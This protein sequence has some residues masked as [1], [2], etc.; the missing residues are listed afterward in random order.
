MSKRTRSS[1][2]SPTPVK[3]GLL[4]LGWKHGRA[5]V[6]SLLPVI[7]IVTITRVA[8]A[9]AYRIPSG[10]MEPTLLVGDW[11]FVNKLRFGPHIPFTHSRLPSYADPRRGDVV[12]FES[13]PQDPSIRITPDDITP[14]LVKRLVG[15]SGDTLAMRGGQLFVNGVADPTTRA[16][17][18]YTDP[19]ALQPQPIFQWQHGIE[20]A[21][22][23]F[24]AATRE[25]SLHEWGPLVIPAGM[26]F[27]M[28]DNRDNS[29]DSRFYGPVPRENVR[30][31]P[32][33]VYYSYD[34]ESGI[35]Y[36]RAVTAIRW[37]RL[38]TWIH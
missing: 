1:G 38:G 9:E 28:G 37:R 3:V 18:A 10:S 13:P 16:A 7:A 20:T 2:A 15:M 34:T 31:N 24:G 14:I 21:T 30:G 35:D 12:V 8:F 19:F 11:L 25:P 4:E 5:L 26:Y 33:F 32:M 36:V 29:V 22:S 27:M 23:R 17:A 6:A